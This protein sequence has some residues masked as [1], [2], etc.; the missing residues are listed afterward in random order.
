[1]FSL[2]FLVGSM[3]P[4]QNPSYRLPR[5]E[6]ASGPGSKEGNE[7]VAEQQDKCRC[8]YRSTTTAL[9]RWPEVT[10]GID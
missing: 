7:D 3:H 10:I 5:K 4:S 8:K 9:L 2:D 6:E 1:M